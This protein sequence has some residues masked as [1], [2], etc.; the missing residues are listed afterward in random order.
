MWVLW[1]SL[2]ISCNV[3]FYCRIGRTMLTNLVYCCTTINRLNRDV[4]HVI[5]YFQ[6]RY[7]ILCSYGFYFYNAFLSSVNAIIAYSFWVVLFRFLLTHTK[8]S[9]Q[10]ATRSFRMYRT[11]FTEKLYQNRRANK[12]VRVRKTRELV[13]KW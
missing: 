4:V 13:V 12:L 7:Y 10:H 11:Y 6:L 9:W 8:G 5:K 2:H 1:F 3:V